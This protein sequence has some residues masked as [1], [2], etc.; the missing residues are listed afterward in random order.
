[1]QARFTRDH[2]FTTTSNTPLDHKGALWRAF[3]GCLAGAGIERQTFDRSG[4]VVDHI[5]LHSLRRTFATSLMVGGADP[6]SVQELLGHKTLAMTMRVY[7]KVRSQT[8]R[9]A[10]AKLS[11]GAGAQG[12]EHVLPLPTAGGIKA[13]PSHRLVTTVGGET[14]RKAE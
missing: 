13:S 12:P 11:Y 4:R 3:V 5:D 8:K 7:A 1:V 10:L 9:Q 2:I 6:K 14:Q